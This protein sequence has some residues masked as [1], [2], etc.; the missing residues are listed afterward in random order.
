MAADVKPPI[1]ASAV[2]GWRDALH[3][4]RAMPEVS[5]IA[6]LVLTAL[7]ATRPLRV[8][9]VTITL[10]DKHLFPTAIG[11]ARLFLLTPLFIAVHRYVL[12]GEITRRYALS[13]SDPRFWRFFTF[14]VALHIFG[15]LSFIPGEIIGFEGPN[16]V[17][18]VLV[19]L[20]L[21]VSAMIIT[22]RLVLL[23][24]AIAIDAPDV[25]WRNALCDTKGHS[26]QVFWIIVVTALPMFI[27]IFVEEFIKLGSLTVGTIIESAFDIGT[28]AAFVAVASRLYR[29]FGD[30]LG[31]PPSIGPVPL[32]A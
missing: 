7:A 5:L 23:F 3:A 22:L 15:V 26:W 12:L 21:F 4:V 11:I 13:P 28:I 31:R 8:E 18:A 24:P 16:R 10:V 29:A 27:L 9:L 17:A 20:V 1:I 25:S 19:A 32:P 6:F 30:R 14:G 2:A